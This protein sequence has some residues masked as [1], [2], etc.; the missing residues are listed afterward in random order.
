MVLVVEVVIVLVESAVIVVVVVE[1]VISFSGGSC[2]CSAYGG[3]VG[4][5]S[6]WGIAESI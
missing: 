6:G 1:V 2:K 3:C 4:S 5:S